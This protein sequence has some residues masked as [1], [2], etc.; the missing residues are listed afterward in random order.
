MEKRLWPNSNTGQMRSLDYH[1]PEVV[2]RHPTSLLGWCQ[3]KLSRGLEHSSLRSGGQLFPSATMVSVETAKEVFEI[4]L[5]VIP[6]SNELLFPQRW[7][8]SRGVLVE[9]QVFHHHPAGMKLCHLDVS[10]NHLGSQSSC[11]CSAVITAPLSPASLWLSTRSE[12]E[13]WFFTSV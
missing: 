4:G 8:G 1:P 6:G 12:W 10:G 5:P 7:S 9:I 2:M 11:H 3:I 13:T